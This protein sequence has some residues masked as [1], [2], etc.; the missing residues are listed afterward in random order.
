MICPVQAAVGAWSGLTY[1]LATSI[2]LLSSPAAD[3][4]VTESELRPE[5]SMPKR[6][7]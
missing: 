6:I 7:G 3:G 5:R 2:H 1:L 4:P